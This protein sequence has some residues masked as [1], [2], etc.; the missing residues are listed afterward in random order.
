MKTLPNL[1]ALRFFLALLVVIFHLPQ[2]FENRGL[3]FYNSLPVFNKGSEAV[4]MFFTLSG[5]LI[6][7]QLYLEKKRTN[8]INLKA[9]YI[10][11]ILRIFPLYYLILTFGFLYYNVILPKLGLEY[12][13]DYNLWEGIILGVFFLPNVLATYSPGG[14]LEILWSIGIEEQ[15]YILVAPFFLFASWR[16]MKLLIIVFTVLYFVLYFSDLL[17]FLKKYNMLFFYF[18]GGGFASL[19]YENATIKSILKKGKYLIWALLI[20]YFTSSFFFIH[21]SVIQYHFL[22]VILF[23]VALAS[24][25][26]S[27][28]PLLESKSLKYLGKISYGIYMYH[29]IVMHLVAFVFIKFIVPLNLNNIF[30][31]SLSFITTVF[32]T[33]LISH[34]SFQYYEKFFLKLKSRYR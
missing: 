12:H 26:L 14:I 8:N 32:I 17:P 24:L 1:T 19:V 25:A 30:F 2:F 7:K 27:E 22:T 6:I 10:R 3:P 13:N 34:F 28:V 18:S 31:I 20:A 4:Y 33:I 11:R 16:K 29:S 23:S 15:F 9:F 21:L 5:F